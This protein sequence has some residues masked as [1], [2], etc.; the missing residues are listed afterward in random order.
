[1]PI[2]R[3]EFIRMGAAAAAL[4]LR[5]SSV[6]ADAADT[7]QVAFVAD[8]HVIDDFYVGPESSPE[9]TESIFKTADRLTAARGVINGLR[10]KVERVFLIGDYF[11]DYPSDDV[12]FYFKNL[13]RIDRAKAITDGFEMP[14]H[15]GF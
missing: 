9:D 13:T 6:E 4:C 1:M 15:V 11:H 7:F 10:P 12:D 3:H 5:P 14:V 2:T 8:S